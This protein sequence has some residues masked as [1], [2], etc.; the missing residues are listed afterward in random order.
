MV[1]VLTRMLL[2]GWR[3]GKPR[4]QEGFRASQE[5]SIEP[6]VIKVIISQESSFFSDLYRNTRWK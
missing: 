1:H 6:H 4:L 5:R 3:L 2:C